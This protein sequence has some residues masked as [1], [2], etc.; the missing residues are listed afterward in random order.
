MKRLILILLLTLPFLA[1]AQDAASK[2]FDRYTAAEGFTS[3][4]LERKMMRMM[5]RQAAEKGDAGLAQLLD[6]IQ[7]IRIV[8]ADGGD[9]RQFVADAEKLAAGDG[10]QLMLAGSEAGQTTRF[11][12]REA[13]FNAYSELLMLTYG[14]KETVVV[15][16]YG[17]FDLRQ[18]ARL[19]T[20][21]PRK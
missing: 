10:F 9:A 8:A 21:R 6:G 13:E 18:V 7:F 11:Y 14:A 3:V 19:S 1:R 16:I 17:K 15:N 12:L 20:I 5:S 4:Q 2:F